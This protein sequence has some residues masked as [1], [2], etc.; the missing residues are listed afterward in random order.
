MES[1][2]RKC[3]SC[4]CL[5]DSVAFI[6]NNKE[7]KTCNICLQ[8]RNK[9]SVITESVEIP[10]TEIKK[11]FANVSIE[12]PQHN[13]SERIE[14]I[15]DSASEEITVEDREGDFSH[16]D[17]YGHSKS[18]SVNRAVRTK[19]NPDDVATTVHTDT[20]YLRMFSAI[21]CVGVGFWLLAR[22]TGAAAGGFARDLAY[23]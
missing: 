8:R 16:N 7:F 21:T 19:R 6:R 17:E 20:N 10:Q 13:E 5:R 3:S 14:E 9:P 15:T 4:K 2:N 1:A 18:R 23:T 22:D 12:F 11:S